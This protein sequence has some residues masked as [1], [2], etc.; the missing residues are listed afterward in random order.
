MGYC[1]LFSFYDFYNFSFFFC[2]EKFSQRYGCF[3]NFSSSLRFYLLVSSSLS[4]PI[5]SMHPCTR[6]L[7][8][9]LFAIASFIHVH[10]PIH[11]LFLVLAYFVFILWLKLWFNFWCNMMFLSLLKSFL[12]AIIIFI[13]RRE[14]TIFC[15]DKLW[16]YIYGDLKAPERRRIRTT[17][18]FMLDLR[19]GKKLISKLLHGLSMSLS[20][21]LI[22]NLVI[23]I[24]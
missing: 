8:C 6:D 7:F 9:P 19:I 11:S 18:L 24:L 23:L 10:F 16:K 17:I 12:I 2:G 14:C 5:I 20:H 4:L 21:L 22:G 15:A 3:N 1:G 13:E